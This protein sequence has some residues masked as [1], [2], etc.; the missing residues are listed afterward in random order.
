M[1]QLQPAVLRNETAVKGVSSLGLLLMVNHSSSRTPAAMMVMLTVFLASRPTMKISGRLL[2]STQ[3]A[4]NVLMTP[5]GLRVDMADVDHLLSNGS[6]AQNQKC[7]DCTSTIA[8]NK[9]ES[10]IN[11]SYP[12]YSPSP[13]LTQPA[14]TSKLSSLNCSTS[15]D[16]DD[17]DVACDENE[18]SRTGPDNRKSN[19]QVGPTEQ[20][21]SKPR[22]S[23]LVHDDVSLSSSSAPV[24]VKRNRDKRFGCCFTANETCPLSGACASH[25]KKYHLC[26]FCMPVRT[27]SARLCQ[28]YGRCLRRVTCD[29]SAFVLQ[30]AGHAVHVNHKRIGV[31]LKNYFYRTRE[32][33]FYARSVDCRNHAIPFNRHTF[34]DDSRKSRGGMPAGWLRTSNVG[35]PDTIPIT[36]E[37]VVEYL[38]LE[39]K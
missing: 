27:D 14:A 38:K 18:R 9:V 2:I 13:N 4:E 8:Y 31:H 35:V 16:D 37:S 32:K 5:L 10:S 20:S 30:L 28:S 1:T 29:S 11:R 23:R 15:L 21:R 19:V 3:E 33:V 34:L 6:P 36:D 39:R 17:D 22:L 12:R 24:Y 25:T 26:D 7:V